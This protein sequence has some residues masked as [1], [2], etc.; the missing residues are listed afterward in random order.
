MVPRQNGDRVVGPAYTSRLI[1]YT[2]QY[3]R[4]HVAAQHADSL[5]RALDCLKQL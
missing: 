4:P 5:R 3:W 2:D 1:E